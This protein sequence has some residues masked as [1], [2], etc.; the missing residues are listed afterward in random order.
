MIGFRTGLSFQDVL[1]QL[2]C[3]IITPSFLLD[4]AAILALDLA[5]ALD[6][7]THAA[8]LRGVKLYLLESICTPTCITS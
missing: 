4:I 6:R 1:L 5:E 7:I 2:S 8:I 3:K